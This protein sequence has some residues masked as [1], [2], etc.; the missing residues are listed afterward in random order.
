MRILLSACLA[1]S[2]LASATPASAFTEPPFR[3]VFQE[4]AL[5]HG[6]DWRLL[7]AIAKK[8]SRF[9]PNA[10]GPNG[11][12][13]LMQVLPE[14]ALGIGANLWDLTD[15][16]GGVDVGA[17]YIRRLLD[18][19]LDEPGLDEET[20]LQFAVAAYHVGPGRL[21]RLR[22][23]AKAKGLDPN[24]WHGNVEKMVAE[25]VAPSSA[26]YVD[27]VFATRADYGKL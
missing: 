23:Q 21:D 24:R 5:K 26:A 22:E 8:E 27:D 6:L 10:I 1:L 9:N 18:V 25:R 4:A 2:L 11:A 16:V 7:A 13:G 12:R 15:P 14:T 20:R 17:R 19:W 3:K